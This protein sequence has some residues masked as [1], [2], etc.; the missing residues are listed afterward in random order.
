MQHCIQDSEARSFVLIQRDFEFELFFH[1]HI[2]KEVVDIL[3][4]FLSFA[5]IYNVL[6]AHNMI[7]LHSLKPTF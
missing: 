5:S 2:M 7:F 6:K 4:S 3:V 1:M